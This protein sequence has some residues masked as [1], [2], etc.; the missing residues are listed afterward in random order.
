MRAHLQKLIGN[1]KGSHGFHHG[2]SAGYN[3]GVVPA[4]RDQLNH[5]SV[6]ADGVLLARDCGRRLEGNTCHDVL[7]VRQASLDAARPMHMMCNDHSSL[8]PLDSPS[9]MIRLDSLCARRGGFGISVGVLFR[10]LRVRE[11]TRHRQGESA[12]PTCHAYLLRQLKSLMAWKRGREGLGMP[13]MLLGTRLETHK[14][15]I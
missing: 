14:S 1:Y 11:G 6:A 5:L 10:I 7:A 15:F 4:A 3:T 9:P 8:P 2:Y 12:N 13:P